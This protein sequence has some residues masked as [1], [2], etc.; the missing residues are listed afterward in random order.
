MKSLLISL[1]CPDIGTHYLSEWSKQILAEAS[2]RN[3]HANKMEKGHVNRKETESRLNKHKPDFVVLNGHGNAYEV[4]GQSEVILDSSNVHLLAET[5]TFV[6]ACNCAEV[7][8]KKAKD[9][10]CRAF[11]GYTKSFWVPRVHKYESIPLQDP[12][13]KPVLESSNKV[14]LA[15]LKGN[16]AESAV[17]ASKDHANKMIL[18]LLAT[19]EPYGKA[20]LRALLRNTD[21]IVCIGDN[22]AHIQ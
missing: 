13:A 8:G 6:R 22:T 1:P 12:A 15:I 2:E 10:K 18:F 7:L 17:K 9:K 3:W 4:Y 14:A 11:I 21:A 20:S 5:I 16:S 19:E